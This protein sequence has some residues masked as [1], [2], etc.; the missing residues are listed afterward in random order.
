MRAGGNQKVRDLTRDTPGC[1]P[2]PIDLSRAGECDFVGQ[3]D[4]SL[5]LLPFPDDYYTAADPASRTGRRVALQSAAMPANKSGTHI[6][7]QPYDLNDGFSPGQSIVLR[8]P[9]LDTP[10]AL[11]ATDPVQLNH[12]GRYAEPDAPVVVIDAQTGERWPIWVEL[13]SNATSPG[14][15]GVDD[16]PGGQLRLRASLHRRAARPADRGTAP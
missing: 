16:Q 15:D 12:L 1:A 10:A 11:A 14:E 7:A 4:G 6:D 2:Q 13:D 3:Q 8:V 5:C 9:G